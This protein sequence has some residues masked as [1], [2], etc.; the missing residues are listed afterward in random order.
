MAL[1]GGSLK[2]ETFESMHS[3]VGFAIAVR[4]PRNT[5]ATTVSRLPFIDAVSE[6]LVKLFRLF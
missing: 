5:L 2:L 1:N 6:R 3:K 4:P